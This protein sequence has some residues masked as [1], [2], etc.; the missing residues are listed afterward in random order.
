MALIVFSG[1]DGAGK[2]T[3]INLI[4]KFLRK[5]LGNKI[6][7]LWARGGYT[8]GFDLIKKIVR[9]LGGKSI[10]SRGKSAHRDR[11]F[12]NS[13]IRYLWLNLAILDLIFYWGIYMRVKLLFGE[14]VICDRYI[15]DTKLDFYLNFSSSG[16]EDY[17]FWKALK[18]IVPSP[19]VYFFLWVPV[20]VSLK[21][22]LLKSEPFPDD[23]FTYSERLKKYLSNSFFENNLP[24]TIAADSKIETVNNQII[25]I[26]SRELNIT[27]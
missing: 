2:T 11:V 4:S 8:P 13:T 16:F 23:E 7:I 5:R 20:D 14:I 24:F 21:R 10:P 26:L 19:D 15:D 18:L 1:T 27:L 17:F 22:S 9:Y 3:Q 12:T 6:S 25:K